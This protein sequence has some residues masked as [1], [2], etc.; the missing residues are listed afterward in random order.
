MWFEHGLKGLREMGEQK[1]NGSVFDVLPRLTL[2]SRQSKRLPM[3][4]P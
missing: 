3:A 1:T 2:S 4:S